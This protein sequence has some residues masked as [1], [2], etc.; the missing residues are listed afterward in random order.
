M[1]RVIAWLQDFG[2]DFALVKRLATYDAIALGNVIELDHLTV[3]DAGRGLTRWWGLNLDY[4]RF[5]TENV[6]LI[7]LVLA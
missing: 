6:E 4:F 3:G 7:R 2:L 5:A 1:K